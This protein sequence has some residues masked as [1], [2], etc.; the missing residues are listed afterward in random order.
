MQQLDISQSLFQSGQLV[1]HGDCGEIGLHDVGD[2][3]E[4]PQ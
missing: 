3:C 4:L 2:G 1:R